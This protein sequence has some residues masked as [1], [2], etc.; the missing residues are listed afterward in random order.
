MEGNGHRAGEGAK[1]INGG[2]HR[3]SKVEGLGTR[4]STGEL[5]LMDK[6]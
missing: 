6:G 5:A 4:H 3:C 1:G 2:G